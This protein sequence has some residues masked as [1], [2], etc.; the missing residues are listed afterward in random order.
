MSV[1]EIDITRDIRDMSEEEKD[2]FVE[3]YDLKIDYSEVISE[4]ENK[5][6]NAIMKERRENVK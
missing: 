1:N 6:F 3:L 4:A 5:L 2:A